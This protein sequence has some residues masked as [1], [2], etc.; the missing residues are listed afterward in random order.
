[1]LCKIDV[2]IEKWLVRALERIFNHI[3]S[4]FALLL[5]GEISRN[6]EREFYYFAPNLYPSSCLKLMVDQNVQCYKASKLSLGGSSH[7]CET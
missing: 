2:Q 7:F 3:I 4:V 1:M 5:S 6:R